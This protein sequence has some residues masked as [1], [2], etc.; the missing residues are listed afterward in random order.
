MLSISQGDTHV[1]RFQRI[2]TDVAGLYSKF[3]KSRRSLSLWQG[4]SAA[5]DWYHKIDVP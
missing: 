2:A 3:L 4:D 1:I 5:D